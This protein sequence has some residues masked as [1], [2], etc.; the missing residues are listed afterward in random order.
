MA[1]Y[2]LTIYARAI[3]TT[4]PASCIAAAYSRC[5]TS[6]RLVPVRYQLPCSQ[7]PSC[8]R[9][10]FS[11]PSIAIASPIPWFD[12]Y[13]PISPKD[14]TI[15]RQP[16]RRFV[17]AEEFPHLPSEIASFSAYAK[18]RE[19]EV[20]AP[21]QAWKRWDK[22]AR[23]FPSLSVIEFRSDW[24]SVP[25][26]GSFDTLSLLSLRELEFTGE[27]ALALR[28]A[29]ASLFFHGVR[30]LDRFP[31]SFSSFTFPQILSRLS[32]RIMVML[33][34]RYA[35]NAVSTFSGRDLWLWLYGIRVFFFFFLRFTK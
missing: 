7:P 35:T 28:P 30:R 19:R 21:S 22:F 33:E 1:A 6:D 25:V 15:D 13:I 24:P 32:L 9:A 8:A 2:H 4:C 34:S 14:R 23:N 10:R 12:R 26:S 27:Q 16:G 11:R 3:H 17:A 29:T 31:R 18:Q 5:R 20:R